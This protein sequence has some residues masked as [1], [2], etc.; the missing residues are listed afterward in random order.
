MDDWG[1]GIPAVWMA[2]VLADRNFRQAE[3]TPETHM[4]ETDLVDTHRLEEQNTG[5][6]RIHGFS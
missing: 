4:L 2:Q 5:V 3:V 6:G 1:L